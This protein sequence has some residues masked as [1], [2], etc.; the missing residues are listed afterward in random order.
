M[1]PADQVAEMR[2]RGWT[3]R[4]IADLAGCSYCAVWNAAHE[5]R[6]RPS[7]VEAIADAWAVYGGQHPGMWAGYLHSIPSGVQ[8]HPAQGLQQASAELSTGAEI[9]VKKPIDWPRL[10]E[11]ALLALLIVGAMAVVEGWRP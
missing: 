6:I 5:R 2:C 11:A 8:V 9:A 7:T 1:T 4:D 10:F 3:L